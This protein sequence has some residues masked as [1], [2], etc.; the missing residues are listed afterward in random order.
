MEGQKDIDEGLPKALNRAY[1]GALSRKELINLMQKIHSLIEMGIK[2][3]CR[4]EYDGVEQ[5]LNNRIEKIKAG[6]IEEPECHNFTEKNEIDE[7][8]WP[9]YVRIKDIEQLIAA[10]KQRKVYLDY[11]LGEEIDDMRAISRLCFEEFDKELL[12]AFEGRYSRARNYEREDLARSLLNM[13]F[14]FPE[15]IHKDSATIKNLESLKKWIKSQ[16]INDSIAK[17][18]DQSFVDKIE[19]M[20]NGLVLNNKTR[21]SNS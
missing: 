13:S 11:L 3:P 1:E 17:L 15:R 4:V 5:G 12:C 6:A 7:E 2:L 19:E 10:W 20:I 8:A 21:Y 16:D 14:I 18:I 9:I